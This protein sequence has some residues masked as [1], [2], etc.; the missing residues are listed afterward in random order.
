MIEHYLSDEGGRDKRT[1]YRMLC[2][3]LSYLLAIFRQGRGLLYYIECF[4]FSEK[5]RW[6]KI[7]YPRFLCIGKPLLR[8]KYQTIVD[9]LDLNFKLKVYN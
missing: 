2:T 4:N 3:I 7:F 6:S 9:F 5:E 1:Y 8:T